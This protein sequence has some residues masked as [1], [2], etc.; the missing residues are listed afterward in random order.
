MAFDLEVRRY[1]AEADGE[2][3]VVPEGTTVIRH[4]AFRRQR[5]IAAIRLPGTV[6]VIENRAFEGCR[7]L[8]SIVLPDSLESLGNE[9][10]RDCAALERVVLPAAWPYLPLGCF[11]GCRALR[12]IEGDRDVRSIEDD[13]LS[14][15][16]SLASFDARS[17]EYVGKHALNGCRALAALDF[18]AAL[19]ALGE[20]ALAYC[21]ALERVGIPDTVALM[22]SD[23][24]K[25]CRKLDPS[26]SRLARLAERFP[27]A[28]GHPDPAA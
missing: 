10:F 26:D 11:W 25:G 20:G 8:A 28:F 19:E 5:S 3:V 4:D 1:T 7:G 17:V 18:G 16:Q 27:Q 14:G 24:F 15:C 23:V 9:A 13:A 21:T 22:G 12:A 6:R 2:C